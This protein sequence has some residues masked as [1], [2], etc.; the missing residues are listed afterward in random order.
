M[1]RDKERN[2]FDYLTLTHSVGWKADQKSRDWESILQASWSVHCGRIPVTG[3][4]AVHEG[5]T[6]HPLAPVHVQSCD[7]A[8]EMPG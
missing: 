4:L 2:V 6:V 1:R 8:F 5:L 7:C 3:Q